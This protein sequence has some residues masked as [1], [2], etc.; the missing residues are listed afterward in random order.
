[1]PRRPRI[2]P[3]GTCFHIVNRAVARLQLFEK[4]E[5]YEAFERV[6]DETFSR[7]PLPIFAYTVMPNHW[8]FVVRPQT[9]IQVT[10]FFRWLTHT[11]SMRWHA[12]YHTEGSGHLYQGRFKAFP[13]EEDD[14]LLAV[15]RYVE[16]NPLH[17]S[18]C[19]YAEDWKYGSFWRN[20]HGDQASKNLLSPWPIKR[21]R[22]WNAMV[23][24]PQ[25]ES[26][27]KTIRQCLKKGR[28]YGNDRFVSQSAVRLQLK[29][30]LH[31]RGRPLKKT[32]KT[33]S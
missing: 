25:S 6:L 26:V 28:P 21:P 10:D 4:Q 27:L 11:H 3:A 1:M 33:L 29:H 20:V 13:I 2:C 16:R 15:L 22:T 23:N 32:N 19:K 8:H 24:R 30:T 17:A 31:S 12:H 14:H 5:D 18:L 7:V 9:K